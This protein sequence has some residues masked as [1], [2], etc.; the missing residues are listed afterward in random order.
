MLFLVLFQTLCSRSAAL[1]KPPYT[2][3]SAFKSTPSP[4]YTPVQFPSSRPKATWTLWNYTAEYTV[5]YISLDHVVLN[6]CSLYLRDKLSII[7]NVL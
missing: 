4:G 3:D 1:V 6:I 7:I 2:A 5:C